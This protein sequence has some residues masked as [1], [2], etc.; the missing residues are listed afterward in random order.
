MHV[1]WATSGLIGGQRTHPFPCLEQLQEIDCSQSICPQAFVNVLYSPRW[2]P[3]PAL[4]EGTA[5][6]AQMHPIPSQ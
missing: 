3:W 2:F 4:W 6:N 1:F 5:A